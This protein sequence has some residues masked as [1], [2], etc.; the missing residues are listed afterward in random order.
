MINILLNLRIVIPL[1][2]VG[3]VAG[4]SVREQP[5]PEGNA[6]FTSRTNDEGT[7]EFAFGLAWEGPN[8]GSSFFGNRR[9]SSRLSHDSS[10]AWKIRMEERAVIM[11]RD[12]LDQESLCDYKHEIVDVIWERNRVRLMGRCI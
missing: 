5:L 2:F 9:N 12:R 6:F 7:K 4:C 3:L 8:S 1:L 11:L 10:G